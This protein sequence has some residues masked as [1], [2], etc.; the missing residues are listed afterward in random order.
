MLKSTRGVQCSAV[1]C[2]KQADDVLK[3]TWAGTTTAPNPTTGQPLPAESVRLA[4][5]EGVTRDMVVDALQDPSLVS[6][7]KNTSR[8]ALVSAP[9]A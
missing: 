6:K 1:Q 3:P 5:R 9:A 4:D 7:A 2:S 8:P